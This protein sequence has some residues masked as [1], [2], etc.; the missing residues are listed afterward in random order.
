MLY[1]TP[2][3]EWLHEIKFLPLPMTANLLLCIIAPVYSVLSLQTW[4]R[5][6]WWGTTLLGVL[7]VHLRFRWMEEGRESIAALEKLKYKAKGA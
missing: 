2:E 4:Q 5:V 7:L 6:A 1:L 3:Q